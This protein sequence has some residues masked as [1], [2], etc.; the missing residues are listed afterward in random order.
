ML[1]RLLDR[2]MTTIEVS[3]GPYL[4]WRNDARPNWERVS[5]RRQAASGSRQY[6]VLERRRD[7]KWDLVTVLTVRNGGRARAA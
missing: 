5:R 1:G 6:E 7:G 4:V 2:F 3:T